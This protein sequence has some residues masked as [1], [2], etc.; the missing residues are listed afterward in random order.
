MEINYELFSRKCFF[1]MTMGRLYTSDI[2]YKLARFFDG[3][4]VQ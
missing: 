2:G 1:C 3:M 4:M